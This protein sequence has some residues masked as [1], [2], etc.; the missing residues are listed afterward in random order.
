[1]AEFEHKA[2]RNISIVVEREAVVEGSLRS[3]R[4]RHQLRLG[5]AAIYTDTITRQ[6]RASRCQSLLPQLPVDT[7]DMPIQRELERGAVGAVRAGVA[8]LAAVR[9]HVVGQALVAVPAADLA[10][11]HRAP[12]L[13]PPS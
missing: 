3:T 9:Q 12:H 4:H 7:P 11:T 8:L 1:M 5:H 10:P 6:S 2:K 13:R